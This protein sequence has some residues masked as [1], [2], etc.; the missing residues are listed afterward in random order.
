M[1]TH[2][3][4]TSRYLNNNASVVTAGRQLQN[5][6]GRDSSTLEFAITQLEEAAKAQDTGTNSYRAF[7][8][9][10]LEET[11]ETQKERRQKINGDILATVVADLQ[12]GSVFVAA[13]Q[14][15]G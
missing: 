9:S 11:K 6:L 14:A 12:V 15:V 3:T 13:G 1:S 7:M 10:A 2:I 8:F 4:S 5:I